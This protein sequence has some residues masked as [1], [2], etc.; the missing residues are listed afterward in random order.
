MIAQE[1]VRL[2]WCT[3]AGARANAVLTTAL[4]NVAPELLD[5]WSYSNLNISLRSD[6][7]GMAVMA[8][9]REARR[10]YGDDLTR[11]VPEVSEQ[12]L[13]KLKFSE[14][15]PPH[16]AMLTRSTRVA[17]RHAASVVGKHSIVRPST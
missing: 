9:L 6:A 10:R 4:G 7:T 1:H 16:L 14:L 17:D 13:K 2:K 11:V 15:L 5:V 12:A 8:A 3:F